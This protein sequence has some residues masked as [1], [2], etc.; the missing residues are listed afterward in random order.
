MWHHNAVILQFLCRREQCGNATQLWCS[1]NW[2]LS[3]FHTS[4]LL[5][6]LPL[7]HLITACRFRVA[8]L[9]GHA[10]VAFSPRGITPKLNRS[11]LFAFA[12]C[13][14][15]QS[16]EVIDWLG[17]CCSP[18]GLSPAASGACPVVQKITIKAAMRRALSGKLMWKQHYTWNVYT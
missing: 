8:A 1:M 12:V 17:W 9:R 7:H 15:G 4:L 13:R 10:A 18:L 3:W 16:G 6:A 14:C 11:Q 5:T 2:P